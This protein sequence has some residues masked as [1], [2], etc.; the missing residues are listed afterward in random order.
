MISTYHNQKKLGFGLA[1]VSFKDA[2]PKG[3]TKVCM[4]M[5]NVAFSSEIGLDTTRP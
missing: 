4:Q 1:F 2:G 3:N 5:E